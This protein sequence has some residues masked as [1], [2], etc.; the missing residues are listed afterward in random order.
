MDHVKV[1]C[2]VCSVVLYVPAG[3]ELFQCAACKTV[4]KVSGDVEENS[5]LADE[6]S[7]ILLNKW[8]IR[9]TAL[10]DLDKWLSSQVQ[11]EGS[12]LACT[13]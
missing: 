7:L 3:V 5:E 10:S 1:G 2:S 4:L 9:Q 11:L 6:R 13:W 12:F 8:L